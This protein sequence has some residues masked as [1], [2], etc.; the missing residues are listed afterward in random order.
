MVHHN[1]PVMCADDMRARVARAQPVAAALWARMGGYV[2]GAPD[3]AKTKLLRALASLPP[4]KLDEIL[5]VSGPF[6]SAA[7]II[8][9]AERRPA[10]KNVV[11]VLHEIYG[12]F[13]S[14]MGEF[15]G[16]VPVELRPVSDAERM[17]A[18]SGSMNWCSTRSY[19]LGSASSAGSSRPG[20]AGASRPESAGAAA[21]IPA[22]PESESGFEWPRDA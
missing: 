3:I 15:E 17:A 8:D 18:I 5:G 7:A 19:S 14:R 6:A 12:L 9:F 16:G 2:A 21:S 1:F 13:V 4:N 20:S 22:S 11:C 10:F